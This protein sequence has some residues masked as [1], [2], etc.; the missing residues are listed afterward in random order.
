LNLRAILP[1]TAGVVALAATAAPA[2]Q[3]FALPEFQSGYE[4]PVL[5]PPPPPAPLYDYVDL[6]VL[7]AALAVATV[8]ALW[9]R[10]RRGLWL[11]AVVAVLYF[12]LWRGGCICAVGAVQNVALALGDPAYPLPWTV[13]GFFLLPLVTTLLFG[14][15]F[16]AAVC[17]L[18]ALQELVAL[19]PVAVPRWLDQ[20][21]GLL[22]YLYLGAAVLFAATGAAF[23]ICDYDPFV[24]VFRLIPLG[25]AESLLDA[26][27]G[28]LT[29]LAVGAAVL[30]L[31]VFIAR[32]YCRWL[33]PYGALLR[34]VSRFSRWHVRITPEECIRCRLCEDACPVGAILKP[35]LEVP[36][37]ERAVGRRRLAVLVAAVPIL[38]AG[39]AWGG[40]ALGPA[41][42][43]MHYTVRQ[44]D[45]VRL[46]E[47]GL[48][49][50]IDD[51]SEAFYRT[52]TPKKDLYDRAEAVVGRF[53][54][55]G[56]LLGLWA[57]VVVSAKLIHLSIW[58]RREDYQPDRA[59]CVSCGRCFAYCP[60]EQKRRKEK[61]LSGE[62]TGG[63]GEAPA[64]SVEALGEA[65][66][67]GGSRAAEPAAGRASA[68]PSPAP[69]DS[70]GS[71]S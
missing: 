55:G 60:V 47:L 16:C 12:G 49:E 27:P 1:L 17:P 25:R 65:G 43:R 53:R 23:V 68:P 22:A 37:P 2:A 15:T 8:L 67:S 21:L 42:A 29:M 63:R 48:V 70:E 11:T 39:G 13:L 64:P 56:L 4:R 52:Q 66:A 45:R 10:S 57:A 19:R 51:L 69:P 33:C 35:T 3:R 44:A 9:L 71:A 20:G 5:A 41:L 26:A 54:T 59:A 30:A 6:A 7:A 61:A 32:P 28:S 50:G 46:E 36:E 38:L 62:A 18:G 14:R 40:R 58:R 24:S 31:G 34:M